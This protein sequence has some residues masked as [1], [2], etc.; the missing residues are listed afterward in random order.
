MPRMNIFFNHILFCNSTILQYTTNLESPKLHEIIQPPFPLW[1]ISP[2]DQP[3][4]NDKTHKFLV[5]HGDLAP[6]IYASL[7]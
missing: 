5:H 6:G 7:H 1:N 2:S 4:L 3:I